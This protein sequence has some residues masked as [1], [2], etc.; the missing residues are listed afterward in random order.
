MKGY[1]GAL[2]LDIWGEKK[3]TEIENWII[4]GFLVFVGEKENKSQAIVYLGKSWEHEVSDSAT[5]DGS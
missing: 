2:T 3:F 5:R 4:V 1:K